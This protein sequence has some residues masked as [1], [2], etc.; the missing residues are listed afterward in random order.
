[1]K[2]E[3]IKLYNLSIPFISP[4]KFSNGELASHTCLIVAIYS[5]GLIGWG[6]CPT[7]PFPYYTYETIDTAIHVLRKFLIPQLLGKKINSPHEVVKLLSFVRGHNMAKSALDCAIWDLFAKAENKPLS[8]ILGG[9]RDKIK[10]GVSVSLTENISLL[11][12]KIEEYLHQ[13]YQRIKLKI[14]PDCGFKALQAVREKYPNLMLMADANSAFTLNH[15]SLFQAMDDLNLIMME[16]PLGYDDLLDH[17]YLQSRIKTPICLDESINSIH[18]TRLS[19]EL[20]SA[21]IINLKV[22]RVGGITNALAIH[23]LCQEAGIKLWCGGMLESGIGRATNLH[24]ASLPN[25]LLPADISAT[26]R[27]FHQDII[28]SPMILNSQDSTI[29][30]PNNIGI[31]VE[32]L[33]DLLEYFGSIS[34]KLHN[35]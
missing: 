27:Y 10:V 19:I 35:F 15:L 28:D 22:S 12:E 13:G 17:S 1:M 18:D 23:D 26:N 16:Q 11:L 14:S 25:F 2:I 9:V 24:L 33:E 5:E 31:G 29:D 3:E 34:L 30:V 4:F 21:Q 6:E 32:V 20:K 8:Q 7:F